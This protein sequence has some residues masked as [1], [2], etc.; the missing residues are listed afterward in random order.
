MCSKVKAPSLICFRRKPA[1]G[2]SQNCP[3]IFSL[4]ALSILE[5]RLWLLCPLIHRRD[6]DTTGKILSRYLY[7]VLLLA[8]HLCSATQ[9]IL[10]K[11]QHQPFNHSTTAMS[12]QSHLGSIPL[13]DP[14]TFTIPT[15]K[16]AE[17]WKEVEAAFPPLKND[18]LLR[19]ARGEETPRAPV[20][21]M[22]QAGR[23]LPGESGYT[24]CNVGER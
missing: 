15:L 12:A 1:I 13:P 23:Y 5:C 3:S 14:S 7:L 24:D 10:S 4:L 2:E 19:A 16:G 18:L 17:D 22:R 6:L 9:I 8:V 21:V 11:E 20:W